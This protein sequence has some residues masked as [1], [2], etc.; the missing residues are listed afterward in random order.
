MTDVSPLD[1]LSPE[2]REEF[3][4][5]ILSQRSPENP[6]PILPVFADLDND[7]VLDFFSV[8]TDDELVFVPGATLDSSL[9][10]SDG[11]DV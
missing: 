8:N 6:N 5:V 2:I 10:L 9:F 7:G 11:G 3:R 4:N 1:K